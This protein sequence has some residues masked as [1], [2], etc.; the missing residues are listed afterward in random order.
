MKDERRTRRANYFILFAASSVLLAGCDPGPKTV[1]STKVV[2]PDGLWIAIARTDVWSGPV[3]GT[4]ASAICVAR[5]DRPHG[6]TDVV[7][8]PEGPTNPHPQI[9]WQSDKELLVRVP[10][11]SNLYQQTIMFAR[12]HIK[13]ESL[14][15]AGSAKD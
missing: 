7:V 4:A 3:V 12:L 6:C 11:P 14:D 8:Y 15:S 13:L 5:S 2:S 9:S 1:W 10:N